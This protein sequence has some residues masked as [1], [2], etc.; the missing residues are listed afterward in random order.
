MKPIHEHLFLVDPK[1]YY[2][3]T[4]LNNILANEY[5]IEHNKN[6]NIEILEQRF[7]FERADRFQDLMSVLCSFKVTNADEIIEKYSRERMLKITALKI[8]D[9]LWNVHTRDQMLEL[10]ENYD[11][12]L[13]NLFE[14][15]LQPMRDGEGTQY[16]GIIIHAY[17]SDA[18]FQSKYC[19]ESFVGFLYHL[20]DR[21]DERMGY[22]VAKN[23]IWEYGL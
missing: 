11:P 7:A 1:T 10:I 12:K 14:T 16:Q 3:E 18:E 2:F 22:N 15:S 5:I 19:T 21:Y 4:F 6:E 20:F 8:R 17:R 13:L 23:L 9:H